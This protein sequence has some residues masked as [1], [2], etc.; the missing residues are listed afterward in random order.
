MFDMYNE[1]RDVDKD[2]KYHFE[3]T[4][5]SFSW[6]QTSNVSQLFETIGVLM[7]LGMI[8]DTININKRSVKE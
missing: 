6:N 2:T 3:V 7:V 1:F 4:S 8:K 5:G